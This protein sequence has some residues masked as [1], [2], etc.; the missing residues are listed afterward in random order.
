MAKFKY[1]KQPKSPKASASLAS[2]EAYHEKMKAWKKAC[3]EVDRAKAAHQKATKK[4]QELK[5]KGLS[6]LRK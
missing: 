6:G 4:S 5:S 3:D 2:H 1:P